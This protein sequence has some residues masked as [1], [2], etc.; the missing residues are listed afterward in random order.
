V[1]QHLKDRIQER[2]AAAALEVFAARGFGGA[3]MVEIARAAGVSTGNIYRYYENK[4][5]LFRDVVPDELPE[6][7]LRLVRRRLKSLGGVRDQGALSAGAAFHLASEELL[8]FSLENRLAVVVLL[9]RAE[10]TPH[11]RFR[12]DLVAE[13]EKLALAH[14]RELD[15]GLEVSAAQRHALGLVY[16]GLVGSMTEILA[17]HADEREIRRELAAYQ[18]YHL[19][20][21]KGLLG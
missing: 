21:L 20:G 4:D 1:A 8:A 12:D 3:T 5:V 17:R 2:I 9:A 11:A 10:G 15:P 7:L 19:A 14:F 13:L 6:R 16:R 18:R